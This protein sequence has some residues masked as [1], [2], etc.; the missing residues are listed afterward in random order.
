[1]LRSR[2]GQRSVRRI[3]RAG[4]QSPAFAPMWRELARRGYGDVPKDLNVA[5]RISLADLVAPA[6]PEQ[7]TE[8]SVR[9]TLRLVAGAQDHDR[10]GGQGAT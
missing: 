2:N 3:I 5:A 7:V 8:G 1:M 9:S 10:R 4:D 6:Q